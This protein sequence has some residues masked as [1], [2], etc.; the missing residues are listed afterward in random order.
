MRKTRA[1]R[2]LVVLFFAALTAIG[3]ATCGDYGVPT[4]EFW[5]Q[6]TLQENMHEYAVR[7][8]QEDTAKW[9]AKQKIGL[10]SESTEK[11]HGQSAY[12]LFAPV[13]RKL[14]DQ[15]DQLH[16]AW[17]MYTWLWFM[18]GV[19]AVYGFSR[20]TGMTR[21]TSCLGTMVL[22]LCPRFFAEGHYQYFVSAQHDLPDHLLG[23]RM[24]T[25]DNK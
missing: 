4:D 10:I 17:L 14:A 7:F 25:L 11:D 5:E 16:T 20:E 1:A 18:A 2:L 12:Y 19:V 23:F 22:Y 15:P 3:L 9:Y 8:G 13:M 24:T 6:Q 21:I